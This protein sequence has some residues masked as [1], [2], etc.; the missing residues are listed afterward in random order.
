MKR[1][2]KYKIV[3]IKELDKKLEKAKIEEK[4]NAFISGFNLTGIVSFAIAGATHP[5][6]LGSLVGGFASGAFATMSICSLYLLYKS[7]AKRQDL[8]EYICNIKN[9][10]NP[11][12][13]DK[14]LYKTLK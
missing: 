5:N 1:D 12:E 10:S 13:D 6:K 4:M 9:N 11:F 3:S 7:T 8:Q 14:P 2:K